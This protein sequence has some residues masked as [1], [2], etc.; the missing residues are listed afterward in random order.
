MPEPT[1]PPEPDDS[2]LTRRRS[3]GLALS[4]IPILIGGGII[5]AGL[6]WF[7]AVRFT[8]G[9]A[10]GGWIALDLR[11]CPE[12]RQPLLDRLQEYGLPAGADPPGQDGA[13]RLRLQTP[14]LDDDREHMPVALTRPGRFEVWQSGSLH[15]SRFRDA[16]VQIS[17]TGTATAVVML[18]QGV[19]PEG[20]EV[21]IDG[22]PVEADVN[23][24][25]L[26]LH[27]TELSSRDALRQA[28]DWVVAIR[29][30]LPCPVEVR[31]VT[32]IPAP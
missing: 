29:H 20:L 28:T 24:N 11:A 19:D 31:S 3:A 23:G 13:L 14:G 30:P 15:M 4:S 9:E 26:Q 18:D 8:S 27:I 22:L 21:R 17:I 16:G 12:A 1:P 10:K 6:L 32:D 2:V 7:V 5:L 25:E